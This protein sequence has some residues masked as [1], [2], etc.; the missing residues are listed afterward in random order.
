VPRLAPISELDR[1]WFLLGYPDGEGVQTSEDVWVVPRPATPP[2]VTEP[3]HRVRPD[4]ALDSI[5]GVVGL[6]DGRLSIDGVVVLSPDGTEDRKPA[7]DV[8]SSRYVLRRPM[9]GPHQIFV[10]EVLRT[11]GVAS[12]AVSGTGDA[13]GWTV[14]PIVL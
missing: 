1:A 3:P 7:S 2:A 14:R 4:P 9:R 13:D 6:R 11:D 12:I 8:E 5:G 10:A